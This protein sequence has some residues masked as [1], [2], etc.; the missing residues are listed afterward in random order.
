MNI[1]I[2]LTCQNM[3]LMPSL[4]FNSLYLFDKKIFLTIIMLV[5]N[6]LVYILRMLLLYTKNTILDSVYS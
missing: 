4:I 6:F 1:Q 2:Y 5:E 3:S